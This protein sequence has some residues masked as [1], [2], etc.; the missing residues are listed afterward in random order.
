MRRVLLV[1]LAV[2]ATGCPD[3][4]DLDGSS[5]AEVAQALV[6]TGR[7]P[8]ISFAVLRQGEIVSS[9]SLGIAD[10]ETGEA[11]GPETLFEG[12]SLT[13]P[14]VATIAMRLYDEGSF[15]LDEPVA[16]TV[17]AP[18]IRDRATFAKV[19][20]RHLL[21]HTS[22][23]PNWSGD[24]LDLDRRDELE[25]A[26][27]PGHDFA[28]SGEGYDILQEFLERRSGRSLAALS[29]ELFDELGMSH[30]TLVGASARGS[31][32]RGHWGRSPSRPARRLDRPVAALSMLTTA[33]DYVRLLRYVAEGSDFSPETLR[34]FRAPQVVIEESEGTQGEEGPITLGWSLGW[35]VLA[36]P[37]GTVYFQWGDNGAF[38][39]FAAFDPKRIDGIVYLTNGSDGLLYTDELA[40]P[41]L[42]DLSLATSWFSRPALEWVRRIIRR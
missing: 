7:L 34:A 37:G 11:V 26:F 17:P 42:G 29:R 28:Y 20:P 18:R 23:L 32:A 1:L 36:G 5:T 8:G 15:D 4:P 19:T 10:L 14:V 33:P 12:A 6:D 16:R 2:V 13:K 27:Q 30:S 39:A 9:G 24:P 38:R 25:F 21:S 31:V 35:G 22:G 3:P 40:S 41:V